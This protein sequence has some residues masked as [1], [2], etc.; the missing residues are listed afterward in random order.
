MKS[1]PIFLLISVIT[2][3]FIIG[4][5]PTQGDSLIPTYVAK[6]AAARQSATAEVEQA[7]ADI[8]TGTASVPTITPTITI[9]PTPTE[10]LT[11]TPAPMA[12]VIKDKV[13]VFTGPAVFYDLVVKLSIGDQVEI[14]GKSENDAWLLVK[15]SD[16]SQ[17]WIATELVDFLG[18]IT[19]FADVEAPPTPDIDFT[20]TIVNNHKGAVRFKIVDFLDLVTIKYGETYQV[21]IP[22]GRYTFIYVPNLQ[23][24]PNAALSCEKTFILSY[25][26]YWAPLESSG[27]NSFP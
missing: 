7:L 4:C 18:Q 10:T 17:G 5:N 19:Q 12:I 26:I 25:D 2:L 24:G 27:C 20:I 21:S 14:L 15:L 13:P 1:N 11:P 23:S 9:T 22:L 6:T 16:G 8:L 3:L